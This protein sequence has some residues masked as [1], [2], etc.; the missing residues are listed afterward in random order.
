MM[1]VKTHNDFSIAVIQRDCRDLYE[2][3][4][5]TWNRKN[6]AGESEI[7]ESILG[8]LPLLDSLRKRHG[9]YPEDALYRDDGN[10][11]KEN[12]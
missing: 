10:S 1:I 12:M 9:T 11:G 2:H 3:F 7:I 6:V 5:R 8:C 4:V